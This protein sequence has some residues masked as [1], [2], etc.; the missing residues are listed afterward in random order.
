MVV[1]LHFYR[2]FRATPRGA[3]ILITKT[4]ADFIPRKI[5]LNGHTEDTYTELY[6]IK[7][8]IHVFV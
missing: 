7:L 8:A 4:V 2:I 3:A 6:Y 1:Y 5:K